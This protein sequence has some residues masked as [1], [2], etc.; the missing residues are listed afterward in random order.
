MT[1]VG[2]GVKSAR[3]AKLQPFVY[4]RP[5]LQ[6]GE[7][8]IEIDYCGICHSDIHQA[9]DDWANTVW[10]CLPGH[11]II[12]RVVALG[13]GVVDFA[14]GQRVGVG[15]MVNSC[16]TCD[17]CTQAEEQYCSGPKGATLTYNGPTKPDGTNTYGGYSTGIIVREEFVLEI[18]ERIKSE[19][20]APILCAG[21][22][23]YA[24]LMYHGVGSGWDVAIAGIGGLGHMAIQLAKAMGATVT[25]LT[26]SPGKRED[27][28][29]LGADEVILM[30]DKAAVT[31]AEGRFDL[32]LSTIPY[33]HDVN[34]YVNM[35]SH[36]GTLHFVGQF[37]PIE[38]LELNPILFKRKGIMGSLIGGVEETQDVLEFCAEHNIRPE[39][40]LIGVDQID[41]A[42][43]HIVDED[44]RFRYVLDCATIRPYLTDSKLERI[45][46]PER[47]EVVS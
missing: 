27:I 9:H 30:D 26:T 13:G 1:T 40:K 6:A 7:V 32:I 11:E 15:C 20:A 10:P 5:A 43:K 35:V 18:P 17:S 29:A 4:E 2:L 45:D 16:Q 34:P 36:D 38:N 46:S 41:K 24:P 39:I 44:V 12:G 33:A 23:T 37:M 42:W 19:E 31:A 28:L 14:I 25:A 22:T 3:A 47:G 21:V 8:Q